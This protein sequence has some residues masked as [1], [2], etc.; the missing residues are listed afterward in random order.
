[1]NDR[2]LGDGVH[3]S[4]DAIV[5]FLFGRDANVVQDRAGQLEKKPSTTFSH[6][7][8]LGVKVNSKRPAGCLWPPLLH[9]S[10]DA[11]HFRYRKTAD[12]RLASARSTQSSRIPFVVPHSRL[13]AALLLDPA[14]DRAEHLLKLDQHRALR[15][16][17]VMDLARPNPLQQV[18]HKAP[19]LL[20]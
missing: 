10:V 5:E 12:G 11:Q 20:H 1:M 6:E 9:L 7:P 18:P 3:G 15:R 16:A 2:M 8:C 19:A 14:V 17:Q 4:H 13:V